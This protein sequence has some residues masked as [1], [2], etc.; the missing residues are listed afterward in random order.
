MGAIFV[1][2][3]R[4][5]TS[6]VDLTEGK[7]WKV[8]LLFSIPVF[9]SLILNNAFLL[10]NALVLKVTV[11]G[12]SVT[13][14]NSTASINS[15][16]FQFAYGASGGF[17]LLIS[18][19]VGKKEY[20]EVKKIFYNGTYLAI[21][22]GLFCSVIGLIFYKDLL[23]LLNVNERYFTK[24]YQY[25]EILL[26]GF[27]FTLLNN[28]FSNALRAMG[29]SFAPLVISLIGAFINVSSAFLFT[30]V[31]SLD[32][33]GVA[34]ATI[35]SH[36]ISAVIT[37]LYMIRKYD[38]LSGKVIKKIDK[39]ISIKMLCLGFPLGFQWSVLYIGSFFQD[40]TINAFGNGLATKAVSCYSPFISYLTM[41]ISAIANA[42]LSYVG[43]NYG[44]RD[45]DRIIKGVKNCI[46]IDFIIYILIMIIGFSLLKY[47]PY[48]YLPKDELDI[49]SEGPIVK[50]YCY[51]YLKIILP[52]FI[53]QGLLTTFRSV[54]QG[55]Q[56]TFVTL[57]S[58]F[59]EL[60]ARIFV[61]AVIPS[62]INPSNPLSD[63]SFIGVCFSTPFAWFMSLVIMGIGSYYFIKKEKEK[64]NNEI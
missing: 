63:E 39:K 4:K 1:M 18:E 22:V 17:A 58:G 60:G 7:P 2:W 56:R 37:Y 40:R 59:G 29:D 51:T 16:I 5:L 30:G 6:R 61:C 8:I 46:V 20:S 42:V 62:L 32:T 49:G 21:F 48:I 41:P 9:F 52:C 36:I 27:I 34:L 54:V 26:I 38:F 64:I 15:I 19:Y 28:Y 45:I 57:I 3:L 50:Y 13:A 12:D 44:K 53:M 10:I 35:L 33:K 47:V 25:L 43:Q 23:S 55:I 31:F 11:G 24:A 14:V